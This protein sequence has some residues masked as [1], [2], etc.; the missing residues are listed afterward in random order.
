M[1]NKEETIRISVIT[2]KCADCKVVR[3]SRQRKI[4]FEINTHCVLVCMF[5]KRNL[6]EIGHDVR[7]SFEFRIL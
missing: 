4:H 1:Y 6:V 7:E 2:K 5:Y 3:T